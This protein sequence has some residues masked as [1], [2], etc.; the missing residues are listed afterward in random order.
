[1]TPEA[2]SAMLRSLPARV[3]DAG[4]ETMHTEVGNIFRAAQEQNF[5]RAADH[6]NTPWPPRKRS[7]PWPILRKTRRMLKAA[8][9]RNAPGNIQRNI[10]RTLELGIQNSAV[11][12]AKFHQ[13]GTSRL[14]TRRFF[15]LRQEDRKQLEPAIRA[16]LMRIMSAARGQFGGR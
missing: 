5:T 12:Y 15:Y 10:G 14:P 11:P 16:H 9:Q 7:Y 4:V 2:F 1:M 8:S 3:D 13:F 6:N